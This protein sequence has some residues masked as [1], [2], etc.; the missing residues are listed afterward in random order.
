[1]NLTVQTPDERL[2]AL[3]KPD[4][5]VVKQFEM[6]PEDL[7]VICAG[8]E[9]RALGVLQNAASGQTPFNVLLIHYEPFFPQNKTD[10]IHDVCQRADIKLVE[11]TYN[12]KD[13]SGFGD[14]FLGR[15]TDCTGRVFVDVSAMSR[16]LIVQLLVAL[17]S[18]ASGFD[19]CY[20]TYAEAADYPPSEA[21]AEAVFAKCES[22]PT[23]S[24]LFLSSG[25]FEVTLIP[26]LS[27]VAPAAAQTRLISFP[28][29]DTH[30][31]T[32]LR[33][34]I[35]PSRYSFIEGVPPSRHNKWRQQMI[36]AMNCLDQIQ[37]AERCQTST[38]D[39]RETLDCL[40]KLY[41]KH[42]GRDRLLI[43]PTGSKMQTVAVGIF[44]AFVRDVQ[45]VYPTPQGFLKP[46]SYTLGVGPLHMLSLASFSAVYTDVE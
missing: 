13:P 32:A 14:T 43:S 27:S 8:F 18:R 12:R 10:A 16:I 23:F 4:F 34:E 30:H 33:A 22:D 15:L 31:M 39:Y 20:V 6:A 2:A 40:L 24:I 46:D 11:V 42:S 19:K 1:M 28:S 17:G 9:D 29:F 45:I 25:V 36:S 5:E 35:Q 41:S 21:E 44:R 3:L 38:L 7:L 37:D 26:E